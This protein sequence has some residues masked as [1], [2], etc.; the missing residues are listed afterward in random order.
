MDWDARL[1]MSIRVGLI[2]WR[3]VVAF[4]SSWTRVFLGSRQ[5]PSEC[6]GQGSRLISCLLPLLRIP[7]FLTRKAFSYVDT[8]AVSTKATRSRLDTPTVE[9][10]ESTSVKCGG[11]T[12]G[13]LI[14]FRSL[15]SIVAL[16]HRLLCSKHRRR[17]V[18]CHVQGVR[19]TS[20]L[21]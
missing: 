5:V 6:C 19:E 1:V 17:R 21:P 4:L 10:K 16:S 18:P 15:D 20:H 7:S 3:Q 12:Y 2:L 8:V 14:F 9:T 11:T 13:W